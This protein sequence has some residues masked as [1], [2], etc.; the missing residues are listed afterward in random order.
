MTTDGEEW[1][2]CEVDGCDEEVNPKRVE[3][4]GCRCLRHGEPPKKYTVAPAFSKGG[5]QLITPANVKDI[6]RAK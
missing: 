4:V 5:Y 3:L 2:I 6:G 1:P